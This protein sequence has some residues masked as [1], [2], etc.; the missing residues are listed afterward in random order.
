MESFGRR[1]LAADPPGWDGEPRG[2][3]GIHGLA[4]PRRWDVVAA[5]RVHAAAA[6]EVCFVVLPDGTVLGARTQPELVRALRV[7][8]EEAVAP[9][10]RAEAVR[11]SEDTWAVAARQIV[12]VD[13]P[14]LEGEHAELVRRAGER[15]LTIDGVETGKRA[16]A[17][18]ELG[19]RL[20]REYVVQATHLG[21]G[22]WEAEASPL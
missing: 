6:D 11:R 3:P 22:R 10:Y 14:R 9:P 13:E 17:L 7:A 16:L 20:G 12:V 15:T 1:A 4:R 8:V 18:E 19:E 21:N 2:E 5:A